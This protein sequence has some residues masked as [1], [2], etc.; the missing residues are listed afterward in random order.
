M[1][2]LQYIS[3]SK[4][5]QLDPDDPEDTLVSPITL[6]NIKQSLSFAPVVSLLILFLILRATSQGIILSNE[7]Y[8]VLEAG[9]VISTVGIVLQ[10]VGL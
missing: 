6:A 10:S 1:F 2:V 8:G 9:F 7:N 5:Q 3:N 4:A